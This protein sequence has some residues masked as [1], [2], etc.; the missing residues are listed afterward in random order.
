MAEVLKIVIRSGESAFTLT[1][2]CSSTTAVNVFAETGVTLHCIPLPLLIVLPSDRGQI[3]SAAIK[4]EGYGGKKPR[5]A[6]DS[7]YAPSWAHDGRLRRH[8]Q[9]LH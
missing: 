8:L 7:V 6:I 4:G 2:T 5:L 1:M 3:L 9:L